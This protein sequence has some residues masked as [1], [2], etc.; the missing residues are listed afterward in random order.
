MLPTKILCPYCKKIIFIKNTSIKIL[1]LLKKEIKN[2]KS[3]E[4]EIKLSHSSI[5][6]SIDILI[7]QGY[8]KKE[9]MKIENHRKEYKISITNKGKKLLEDLK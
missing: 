8:V 6:D 9:K 5:W 4:K 7:N 2:M 1:K 3:I